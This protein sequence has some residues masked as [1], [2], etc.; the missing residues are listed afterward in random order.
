MTKFMLSGVLVAA[1]AMF[2]AIGASQSAAE[3]A[4]PTTPAVAGST[5]AGGDD[6]HCDSS[7]SEDAYSCEAGGWTSTETCCDDLREQWE[8][9]G[10]FKCCGP[11]FL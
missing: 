9:D 5:P 10:Q 8:R 1:C 11:C 7:V 6:E 4:P 3:I 2:G